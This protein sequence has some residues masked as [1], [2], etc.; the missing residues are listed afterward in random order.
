VSEDNLSVTV[1]G[2]DLGLAQLL[3]TLDALG[4]QVDTSLTRVGDRLGS[5]VTGGASRARPAVDAMG[6]AALRASRDSLALASTYAR[7]QAAAGDYAG[8]IARL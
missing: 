8:A 3:R 6:Q 4:K 5:A 1:N 2:R 7:G